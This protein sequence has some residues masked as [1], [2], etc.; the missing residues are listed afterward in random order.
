MKLPVQ[1]NL[2]TPDCY[3]STPNRLLEVLQAF[4]DLSALTTAAWIVSPNP[5]T[6]VSDRDKTW[7]RFND[8][9]PE[10]NGWYRYEAT[11]LGGG[12]IRY[13]SVQSRAV[14]MIWTGTDE[15]LQRFDGGDAGMPG[16][17]SGPMWEVNRAFDFRFPVGAGVNATAYDGGQA[18]SIEV[19]RTGGAERV[20]LTVEEG[21]GKDHRHVFG[22][23]FSPT[24]GAR[25][26]DVLLLKGELIANGPGLTVSG[27]GDSGPER[28]RNLED[29][30]ESGGT[31]LVT[32][33][34]AGVAAT[35]SHENMPPWIGVRFIRRTQ[36]KGYF[37]PG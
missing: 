10:L 33:G 36:R 2:L 12:W 27:A 26:N 8:I 18:S 22:R 29:L 16:D 20:T 13:H 7:L 6:S 30:G 9:Q 23:Q 5:P 19:G 31:Y 28:D 35:K 4:V 11:A 3:P 17:W 1:F 24:R 34:I 32:S 25:Y 37:I 14:H 15:E 21:G